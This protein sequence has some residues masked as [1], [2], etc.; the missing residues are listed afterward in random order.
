[1][2][3]LGFQREVNGVLRQL[4]QR[5]EQLR[6]KDASLVRVLSRL[7]CFHQLI[8][9][10]ITGIFAVTQNSH[11]YCQHRCSEAVIAMHCNCYALSHQCTILHHTDQSMQDRQIPPNCHAGCCCPEVQLPHVR[12][13]LSS[14]KAAVPRRVIG[15][16]PGCFF[17]CST[18]YLSLLECNLVL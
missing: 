10:A 6:Q 11:L 7:C 5:D 4:Q 12:P 9:A 8:L 13:G 2:H 17:L 3:V 18:A 16:L 14:G 1:M 15:K